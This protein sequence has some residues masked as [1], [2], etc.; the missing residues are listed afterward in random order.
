MSV[1]GPH[2]ALSQQQQGRLACEYILFLWNR[3]NIFYFYGI[4]KLIDGRIKC[5]ENKAIS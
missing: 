2:G 4:G 1:L 5:I 3:V